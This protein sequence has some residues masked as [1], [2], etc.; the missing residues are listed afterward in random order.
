MAT[1][2]THTTQDILGSTPEQTIELAPGAE[3]S[4][5]VVTSDTGTGGGSAG[6]AHVAGVQLIAP[7]DT[8]PLRVS[9]PRGTIVCGTSG[10]SPLLVG[11]SAVPGV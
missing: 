11:G 7:D 5:R 9:L 1:S 4:F 2:V 10:V 6:C 3:A 8:A